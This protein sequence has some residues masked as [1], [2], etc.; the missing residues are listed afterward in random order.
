MINHYDLELRKNL[1]KAASYLT[2]PD[3]YASV[4]APD[5]GRT[6]GKGEIKA[7]TTNRGRPRKNTGKN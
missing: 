2:K 6:F 1:K 3:Y 4:I 7:K 5:K